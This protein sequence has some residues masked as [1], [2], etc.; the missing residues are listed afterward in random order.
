MLTVDSFSEESM[1]NATFDAVFAQLLRC[2]SQ[3][4]AL[5]GSL[6]AVYE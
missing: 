3:Q 2:V 1:E 6:Q 5:L 4:L